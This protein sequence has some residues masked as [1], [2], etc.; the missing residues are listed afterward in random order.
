M[1]QGGCSW[2]SL[3]K[4]RST[5]L[6]TGGCVRGWGAQ[7]GL[8]PRLLEQ[9]MRLRLV[10]IVAW[11]CRL[12]SIVCGSARLGNLFVGNCRSI[13]MLWPMVAWTPR[14]SGAS[15]LAA[16]PRLRVSNSFSVSRTNGGTQPRLLDWFLSDGSLFQARTHVRS[17]DGA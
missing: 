7:H 15:N 8:V 12:T 5:L 17:L 13:W 10:R 16:R 14:R 3:A 9:G 2:K 4:I 11:Q 6:L 1:W